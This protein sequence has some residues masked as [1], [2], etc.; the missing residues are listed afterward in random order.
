[1][2][3]LLSPLPLSFIS[4]SLTASRLPSARAAVVGE[5]LVGR[6]WPAWR[7]GGARR[8]TTTGGAHGRSSP[9]GHGR[10]DTGEELAGRPRPAGRRGGARRV[11]AAG[12]APGRSLP[13]GRG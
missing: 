9:G 2:G 8:D 12:R 13:G 3:A 1:M 4:S 7:R 6:P 5:E 10:S 11:A